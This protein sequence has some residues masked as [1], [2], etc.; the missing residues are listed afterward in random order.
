MGGSA[1][2]LAPVDGRTAVPPS[3]AGAGG[4]EAVASSAIVAALRGLLLLL[5]G[6]WLLGA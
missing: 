4:A 2:S 3:A 5:R 1:E 6:L